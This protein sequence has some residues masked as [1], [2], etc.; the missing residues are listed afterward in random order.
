MVQ[1]RTLCLMAFFSFFNRPKH[2]TF[3][4][5]PRFYDPD[6]EDREARM[7]RYRRD[8]DDSGIAKSRISAGFRQR[9]KRGYTG[10]NTRRSNLR[11]IAILV[12]LLYLTYYFIQKYLPQ[13]VDLLE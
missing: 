9:T 1:S 13:I 5:K 6:K 4:Y 10:T 11:L 12:V 3:D 7:A 2:Q 8:A